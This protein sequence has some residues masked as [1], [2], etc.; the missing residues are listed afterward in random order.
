MIGYDSNKQIK[1][2]IKNKSTRHL[3]LYGDISIHNSNMNKNHLFSNSI[4]IIRQKD[5]NLKEE[6]SNQIIPINNS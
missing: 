5:S 6:N 2:L 4:N 1:N 3:R